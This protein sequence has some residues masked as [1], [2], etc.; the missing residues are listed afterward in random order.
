MMRVLLVAFA[1]LIGL[2]QTAGA[3]DLSG[4]LKRIKDTGQFTIGYRS[5][6]PPFSS[7]DA[8][9]QAMGFSIDLCQRIAEGAKQ[10]LGLGSLKV[11]FVPLTAES[12]F[13]AVADGS[14][15]IECGV[16]T[17]TLNREEIVDFSLM[18][19]ITG[20]SL[21]T[22]ADSEIPNVDQLAGKKLSVVA[23]TTTEKA[24]AQKLADLGLKADVIKVKDHAE[25]MAKLDAREVAAHVG[26]QLTLIGLARKSADPGKYALVVEPFTY[27]PYGLMVRRNDAD[28]RLVVNRVLAGLYR[29]GEIGKIYE[30]W[31]G[32]WG[33]KPSR[34]LI[35]MW[36]LNGIP[37]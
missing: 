29:S 35:A 23:G 17:I 6:A 10:K 12:R 31:F 9:K 13:A 16:S 25:A 30:R 15:D 5:D 28:F 4:T 21:M 1:A 34:L 7:E 2:G 24:L 32:D 22:L 27:E 11:V 18:T 37:E 33:G 26:D 19:F 14:V 36:A 3:A 20:A 8:N